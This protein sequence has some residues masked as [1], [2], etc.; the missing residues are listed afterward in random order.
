MLLDLER[1]N[2]LIIAELITTVSSF[3]CSGLLALS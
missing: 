1:S 3:F 2:D